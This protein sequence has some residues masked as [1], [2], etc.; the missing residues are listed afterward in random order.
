MTISRMK[1][2]PKSWW[3]WLT[4]FIQKIFDIL[5]HF[6]WFPPDSS[7][8]IHFFSC[9]KRAF[10][11]QLYP[12]KDLFDT[13]AIKGMYVGGR[14]YLI[15]EL[16]IRVCA[17]SCSKSLPVELC[18]NVNLT[19]SSADHVHIYKS[20]RCKSPV[21][22]LHLTCMCRLDGF[23]TSIHVKV[24]HPLTGM[25]HGEKSHWRIWYVS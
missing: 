14:L 24:L 16:W 6:T 15:V 20:I 17:G 7:L 3:H 10:F 4:V 9:C 5:L 13:P 19:F 8:N 21:L 25:L 23:I 18:A 2:C 22:L 11:F 1:W 12:F